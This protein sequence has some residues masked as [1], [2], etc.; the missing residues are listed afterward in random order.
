MIEHAIVLLKKLKTRQHLDL[1]SFPQADCDACATPTHAMR[2][3]C[4]DKLDALPA[5]NMMHLGGP[6]SRSL[7]ELGG[8]SKYRDSDDCWAP[9]KHHTLPR[10]NGPVAG[11]DFF[12]RGLGAHTRLRYG[13]YT[14]A[15]GA[16]QT[17]GVL[18]LRPYTF[19]L[20]A[21]LGEPVVPLAWGGAGTMQVLAELNMSSLSVAATS[22][23]AAAS[24]QAEAD[25]LS[26]TQRRVR[27]SLVLVGGA[28]LV[29]VQALS[30]RSEANSKCLKPFVEWSERCYFADGRTPVQGDNFWMDLQARAKASSRAAAK[31]DAL[32][33]ETRAGWVRHHIAIFDAVARAARCLGRPTPQ[34]LFLYTSACANAGSLTCF[35]QLVASDWVDAV[36]VALQRRH[37]GGLTLR[38]VTHR[39][40]GEHFRLPAGTCGCPQRGVTACGYF[41]DLAKDCRCA[42]LH[43]SYYPTDVEHANISAA[44][45]RALH[46]LPSIALKGTEAAVA[47]FTLRTHRLASSSA[48]GAHVSGHSGGPAAERAGC[49]LPGALSGG[50]LKHVRRVV[51]IRIQKTG[52]KSLQRV[53]LGLPRPTLT[54]DWLSCRCQSFD[55]S[56][57]DASALRLTNGGACSERACI[58]EATNAT[59]RTADGRGAILLWW[60][61]SPHMLWSEHEEFPHLGPSLQP[62]QTLWLTWLRHPTARV[63]SEYMHARA[64]NVRWDYTLE[65][66]ASL[67]AFV[68]DKRFAIGASNRMVRMLGGGLRPLDSASGPAALELAKRRLASTSYFGLLERLYDSL[69]LLR[70]LFP[71]ASVPSPQEAP[72]LLD[73]SDG[74]ASSLPAS[75]APASVRS[76]HELTVVM[77]QLHEA[78]KLDFALYTYAEDLFNERLRGVECV[79]R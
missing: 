27:A 68:F 54:C 46:H 42:S 9:R 77:A 31:Y 18:A 16:A 45:L 43:Q 23:S 17:L 51:F 6:F 2:V 21:A 64:E 70:I 63:I 76:P 8:L 30:G 38:V 25:G 71:A 79:P 55:P 61:N 12:A 19:R 5:G 66:N 10:Y 4:I 28:R 48:A 20:E 74:T 37:A 72:P 39:G 49:R 58:C 47:P 32:L 62:H 50:A 7:G 1:P 24:A 22:R 69:W 29:I 44:I 53:Q 52:T 15:I 73:A 13:E 11:M 40:D 56:R 57:E 59:E 3:Q 67:L 26:A 65:P 75:F 33:T 14:V 35:P 36:E 78:N 41:L 60:S 34:L